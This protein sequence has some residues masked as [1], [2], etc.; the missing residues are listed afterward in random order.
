MTIL[1]ANNY[2]YLRGGSEQVLFDDM[3]NL[4]DR[5]VTVIPFATKPENIEDEYPGH[6]KPTPGLFRSAESSP[7]S[8]G[9]R[10]NPA[11]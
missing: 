2:Y 9:M 11:D 8:S 6:R 3:K 1:F 10:R 4:R 7:E 5:G